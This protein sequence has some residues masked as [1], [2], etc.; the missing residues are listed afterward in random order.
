MVPSL[1]PASR[2]WKQELTPYWVA[3]TA[4]THAYSAVHYMYID[5]LSLRRC[6]CMYSPSV[7]MQTGLTS[8]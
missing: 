5:L 4:R 1:G 2:K 7:G 3:G 8:F 6:V